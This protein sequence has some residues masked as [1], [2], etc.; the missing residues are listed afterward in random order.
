MKR[1]FRVGLLWLVVLALVAAALPFGAVALAQDGPEVIAEGLNGP[2]GVLVD[3]NGDIWVI[4]SGLGGEEALEVI[5]PETGETLQGTLGNTSRIV[6]ISAADGSMTE[7][8]SLPSVASEAGAS[9]GGRL[10]L[11]DGTLYATVGEWLADAATDPPADAGLATLVTVND[12]G[13]TTE[14]AQFWPYERDVNPY[15]PVLHAHPYGVIGGPDGNI[16]VADAGGNALQVV[17]PTTGEISSFAVF[18]PLP[19]VFPRPEYDMQLLTDPVPTAVTIGADGGLYVS[20]LSGAPFIPGSAKVLAVADDGSFSDF[21][22]GL[23]ML[24]DLRTGPDGN[25]YAAQFGLFTEQGPMPGSGAVIRVKEGGDSEVVVS[26]LDFVTSLDFNADG[27][28]YVTVNGVGAPGSGQ[29]VKFA[30]LTDMA[31]TSV[32]EVMAAMAPPAGD[33]MGEA[34]AEATEEAMEEATPAATEEAA[35]EAAA[36]A[37]PAPAEETEATAAATEEAMEEATPAPTE[38]AMEE[39]AEGVT[40]ETLP[41]TGAATGAVPFAVAGLVL[42]MLG[43]LVVVKRWRKK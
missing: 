33:A 30:G 37:T 40:P 7:V 3:P 23:T 24:T 21:A 13:S 4:D 20:L 18:E 15:P 36:E 2:M 10:A 39:A 17:D 14:V 41:V 31:G 19:G 25:L 32:S 28:A 5:N 16:W 9:G 12:D 35:E 43:G 1:T 29:V 26:G 34:T 6:K 22:T 38:E 42:A 8:A 27:D 11:V